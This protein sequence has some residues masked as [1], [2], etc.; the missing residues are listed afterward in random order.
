V[1]AHHEILARAVRA[2]DGPWDTLRAATVLRDAGV[3]A[4]DDQA[5][6]KQ[7]RTALRRLRDR[8]LLVRIVS[9]G[10]TTVYRRA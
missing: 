3:T 5:A 6:G 1:S 2:L 10:G 7:A 8:G 4:R 9:P